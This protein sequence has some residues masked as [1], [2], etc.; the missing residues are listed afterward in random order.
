MEW[1]PDDRLIMAKFTDYYDQDLLDIRPDRI[2]LSPIMEATTRIAALKTGEVDF[3]FHLGLNNAQE[4]EEAPGVYVVKQ[5]AGSASYS[6]IVF[7]LH[8]PHTRHDFVADSE[9]TGPMADVRV[10]KAIAHALDLDAINKTAF[11]GYGDTNCNIIPEGHWA[12]EPLALPS[13]R[14]RKGQGLAGRGG[15][16]RRLRS[17]VHA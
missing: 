11:F 14:H 2:I 17:E 13:A 7:N 6:T 5:Q 4:I 1:I 9:K 8:Q 12:Y 15:L 16:R 3:I 10:R